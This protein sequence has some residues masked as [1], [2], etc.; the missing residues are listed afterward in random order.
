MI[1]VVKDF[2]SSTTIERPVTSNAN[3]YCLSLGT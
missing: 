3:V 2:L 1:T